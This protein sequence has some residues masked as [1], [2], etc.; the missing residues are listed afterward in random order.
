MRCEPIH[1]RVVEFAPW[2]NV[3]LNKYFEWLCVMQCC[4]LITIL[5]KW[6]DFF[7]SFP[8]VWS[9]LKTQY[10]TSFA[11]LQSNEEKKKIVHN[12]TQCQFHVSA[13]RSHIPFDR[14]SNVFSI[15]IPP[16]K[17]VYLGIWLSRSFCLLVY[18]KYFSRIRT[19]GNPIRILHD[20]SCM[21][22]ET[23]AWNVIFRNWRVSLI[24]YSVLSWVAADG[25]K[26]TD[27][28]VFHHRLLSNSIQ[29]CEVFRECC[30]DTN[31]FHWSICIRSAHS[32]LYL[33]TKLIRS[34]DIRCSIRCASHFVRM[35]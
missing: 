13:Y 19:D 1:M 7:H 9:V 6:S 14:F 34:Y 15:W 28:M 3:F 25:T 26:P 20:L 8:F 22:R 33:S 30:N 24:V 31:P 32:D 29:M 21:Q 17:I 23:I 2:S 10:N 4:T 5:R 18:S 35:G 16:D 11:W 12:H 27:E